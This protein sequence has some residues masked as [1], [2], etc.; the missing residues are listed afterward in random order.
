V[1]EDLRDVVRCFLEEAEVVLTQGQN[2]SQ[3]RRPLAYG[4]IWLRRRRRANAADEM[5]ELGEKRLPR[6]FG[7]KREQLLELIED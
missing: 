6:L 1:I 2:D 5:T 7:L 4:D 3:R